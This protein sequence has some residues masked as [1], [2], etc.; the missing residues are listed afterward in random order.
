MM[1]RKLTI[2]GKSLHLAK[3]WLLDEINSGRAFLRFDSEVSFLRSFLDQHALYEWSRKIQSEGHV[4]S[5]AVP[6]A[7]PK[8]NGSTRD[9]IY[10]P[11][12]DRLVLTASLIESWPQILEQIGWSQGSVDYN[13]PIPKEPNDTEWFLRFRDDYAD[14]RGTQKKWENQGHLRVSDIKQ[15]SKSID[16]GA[17]V[18]AMINAGFS[19]D[20]T[21]LW[22]EAFR[23]WGHTMHQHNPQAWPDEKRVLPI[24]YAFTDVI[25]KLV[26]DWVDRKMVQKLAGSQDAYGR[27]NDNLFVASGSAQRANRLQDDL[28]RYVQLSGME[29]H[30]ETKKTF[31]IEPYLQP[32]WEDIRQEY[33]P[34]QV[35]ELDY[36]NLPQPLLTKAYERLLSPR[37]DEGTTI[38][39]QPLF[40]FVLNRMGKQGIVNTVTDLPQLIAEH[41]DKVGHIMTY[42]R[43]IGDAGY[44]GAEKEGR[45]IVEQKTYWRAAITHLNAS[46]LGHDTPSYH[47]HIYLRF[48]LDVKAHS[49][50]MLDT[51]TLQCACFAAN[52]M[53]D[54]I[55]QPLF[56]QLAKS[57][58]FG[59]NQRNK[60][61]LKPGGN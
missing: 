2:T 56:T 46:L 8:A 6:Y 44:N 10:V 61:S 50:D 38:P 49:P 15:F 20:I 18:M 17:V 58:G 60:K 54:V 3:Y 16:T 24:G 19:Q 31:S 29:L 41:P 36:T 14:F 53:D 9:G 47:A 1:L 45:A 37:R 11:I 21:D 7:V 26:M 55:V 43:R 27:F 48:L 13:R 25:Q 30:E 42:V 39:A 34:E 4:L 23:S 12:Q 22:H 28:H 33:Q 5:Q 52:D 32:L 57:V 40:N 59:Y 51:N 35:E